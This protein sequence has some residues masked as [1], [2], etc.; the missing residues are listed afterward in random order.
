M[1]DLTITA[2]NVTAGALAT[3]VTGTAGATIT[4]GQLVYLDTS[5]NTYKLADA[6]AAASSVVAGVALH[7]AASGQPLTIQTSGTISIGATVA[8]GATYSI[9]ETAGGIA[10]IADLGTGT[11]ISI[12]GVGA[13]TSTIKLGILNSSVAKA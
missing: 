7:G 12:V 4:A 8:V 11:Y 9:S 2:A 6:N 13:T 10:A 5:A 3:T 1:A